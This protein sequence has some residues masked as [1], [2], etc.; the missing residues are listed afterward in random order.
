MIT[1][2]LVIQALSLV[3]QMASYGALNRLLM[4]VIIKSENAPQWPD[5]ENL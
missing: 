2:I 3:F 1:A 4:R 5:R